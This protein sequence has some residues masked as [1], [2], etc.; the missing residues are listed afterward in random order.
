MVALIHTADPSAP[1]LFA[2]LAILNAGV[3]GISFFREWRMLLYL[4]AAA[5][6]FV[7]AVCFATGFSAGDCWWGLAFG[8]FAFPIHA[9]APILY[10][11]CKDAFT[12]C[13]VKGIVFTG[14]TIPLV[15]SGP[16]IAAFWALAGGALPWAGGWSSRTATPRRPRLH[17]RGLR[18]PARTEPRVGRPRHRAP[19]MDR[20]H[21][22]R[23]FAALRL[24][25][26]S[27][28]LTGNNPNQ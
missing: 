6:W 27:L 25:R 17:P 15:F 24:P 14:L 12:V 16:W 1:G 18:R 8:N 13:V 7:Y 10:S 20:P 2:Y 28:A 3:L 11:I 26:K 19:P 21:G 5:T 22:P 9:L 4:G 23:L